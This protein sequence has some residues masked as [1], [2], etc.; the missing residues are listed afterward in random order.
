MRGRRT[1]YLALLLSAVA[2][3]LVYGQYLTHYMVIFLLIVPL[4][5]LVLSLPS[6]LKSKAKLTGGEDVI[7]GR[8]T[9]VR[10]RL[11]PGSF[12]PPEEWIVTVESKNEFT[13]KVTSRNRIHACR[14]EELEREFSPDTSQIGAIRF[15]VI[16]AFVFDRLGLIPIPVGKGSAV[17]LTVLPDMEQ[18]EP[19]PDLIG[20]STRALKPKPQGYSEEHEMRQ[21]RSGD[22]MNLIH[23]KLSG[24]VGDYVVREPQEVVRKEI[25]LI[26]VPPLLYEDHRSVLEQLCYLND[27]LGK[28]DIPYRLQYGQ[29]TFFIRS[30]ENYE[31]TV[32]DILSKPMNEDRVPIPETGKDEHLLYNI[33]PQRGS[34]S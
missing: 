9:R 16:R 5:S 18:P 29:K 6:A 3:H 27:K 12:L 13:G 23:W 34:K 33:R 31:E 25:V 21:Y 11:E 15:R 1:T 10:L 28:N 8:Q 22:P 14:R 2:F 4:I 17:S 26:I 19:D 32:K 20:K 7:R 30:E 24:K